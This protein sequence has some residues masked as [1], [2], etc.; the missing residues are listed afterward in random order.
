MPA[1]ADAFPPFL[2]GALKIAL[3]MLRGVLTTVAAPVLAQAVA[4]W[5]HRELS[6][7]ERERLRQIAQAI[8]VTVP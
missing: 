3:P 5:A 6:E 7:K 1:A 8:L 4:D 2:K